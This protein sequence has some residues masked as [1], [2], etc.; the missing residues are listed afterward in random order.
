MKIN[1]KTKEILLITLIIFI[2]TIIF[3]VSGINKSYIHMDEAFSLGLASYDKVKIQ[4]NDDFYDK[5]HN[6]KYYE[7]YLTV[8]SDEVNEYKQIYIN[9][10]NDVHPPLYYLLL[11]FAMGFSVDKFSMWPGLIINIIIYAFITI[12]MYLIIKKLLEGWQNSENLALILALLSS[13]TLSSLTNVLYIRM[14]ALSTLNIAITTYLHLKLLDENSR[15]VKLLFCIGLSALAGSLTHYYY[16]FYLFMLF[17]MICIKYIK[18]K[19]Y[20]E[21]TSYIITMCIAGILSL[22][23]FPYSI[24]HIFF[25]NRG[26]GALSNFTSFSSLIE[27]ISSYIFKINL[28]TFNNALAFLIIAIAGIILYKQ[29]KQIKLI[30]ENKYIKFLVYPTLFYSFL[31][32]FSAPWK[33]LRYIMPV[34]QMIFVVVIYLILNLLYDLI[35]TK[36]LQI[37][38]VIIFALIIFTP[39]ISNSMISKSLLPIN[40]KLEPEVMYSNRK[41]IVQKVQN[42]LNVPSIFITKVKGNRFLD[43]I[44]LFTYLDNSYIPSPDTDFSSEYI[45]QI[46][47][48]KDISKGLV[49]FIDHSEHDNREKII[50]EFKSTLELKN[51]KYVKR[52]NACDVY[53]LN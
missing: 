3:I 29:I 28:Y 22:I 49:L 35:S 39:C 31:V 44:L 42:E 2:Q 47:D 8:N 11:R 52:L 48:G 43:D 19:R 13:I 1:T 23:I 38:L 27:G 16:L 6:G 40:I 50:N 15:N 26:K 12:F 21:L 20:N 51:E 36:K 46:L 4:L 30:R 33:E 37:V 24:Q 17:V 25:G 41:D 18:E 53:Y 7:D 9:Q 10:K 5:W 32:A 14:Y 45:K 34:C